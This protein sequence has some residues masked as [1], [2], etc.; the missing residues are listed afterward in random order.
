MYGCIKLR[1]YEEIELG[2]SSSL[3]I[4]DSHLLWYVQNNEPN[5]Y[6]FL[7]ASSLLESFEAL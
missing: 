6:D 1:G 7:H 5:G 2:N 3:Y 4:I